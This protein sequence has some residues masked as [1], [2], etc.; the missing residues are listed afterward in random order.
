MKHQDKLRHNTEKVKALARQAGFA[1]CGISKAGFLDEEAKKLEDWLKY[2]MHGNMQY[3]ENHFDKRLDP[4]ALVPGAKSV[5]SLIYNYAPKEVIFH[6]DSFQ[7]ARYAYGR[8]YHFVIKEKLQNLF[9]KLKAEMGQIEGRVFTDSAPVMERT[10]AAKSGIGW[11]GKN[12]LL[13]N[14]SLGSYFFLAEIICDLELEAD[15]P[16]KDYCGSCTKCMDACP[17]DAI[18]LPG[19]VDGSKCISYFTIEHKG[20]IPDEFAGKLNNWIFGCDICQEVCPWNRFSK[21]HNEPDFY[22]SDE[23]KGM[24]QNDWIELTEASFRSL[25]KKSAVKRTKYEGLMRNIRFNNTEGEE[26]KFSKNN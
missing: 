5:I 3:M 23:L 25:F 1:Y 2:G 17:T 16:I 8:D 22:P 11:Q 21:A 4:R 19:L 10:W 24:K 14:R 6:S 18:P 7:I 13:L 15:G 20:E 26:L 9:E 12:S